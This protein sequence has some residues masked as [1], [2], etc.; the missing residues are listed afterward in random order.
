MNRYTDLAAE[1]LHE[2]GRAVSQL[3]LLL[4]PIATF[5]KLYLIKR[6]FQDGVRGL[7]VSAGSAFYVVLKYSKLWERTQ[8]GS[9]LDS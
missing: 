4:S 7:V 6:G 2:S 9:E 3:R 8:K 1:S 5:I